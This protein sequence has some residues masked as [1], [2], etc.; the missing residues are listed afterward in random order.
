MFRFLSLLA[1]LFFADRSQGQTFA[2]E[3][4]MDTSFSNYLECKELKMIIG[5]IKLYSQG[6]I[7]YSDPSYQIWNPIH[8][9]ELNSIATQIS[10]FSDLNIDSISF[11]LGIDSI[12]HYAE[13]ESLGIEPNTDMY[14]TWQS[15]YIHLKMEGKHVQSNQKFQYHLGGFQYPIKSDQLIGLKIDLAFQN[16]FKIIFHLNGS[17]RSAFNQYP[18]KIMSPSVLSVNA[19]RQLSQQ[20]DI[21]AY[22]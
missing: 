10:D 5:K 22:D 12:G 20:F 13:I 1:L 14:W 16:Q 6:Q 15:G 11:Q 19:M 4:E 17:L 7:I 2:F 9:N 8:G 3:I 18:Y 21:K